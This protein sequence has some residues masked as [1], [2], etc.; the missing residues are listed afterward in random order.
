MPELLIK[1]L[2]SEQ[3]TD[4]QFQRMHRRTFECGF[5]TLNKLK[6]H[7]AEKKNNNKIVREQF[8]KKMVF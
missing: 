7:I 2:W 8:I 4:A 1:E 3:S 6:T 5:I